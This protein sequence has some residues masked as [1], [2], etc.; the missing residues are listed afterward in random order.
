MYSVKSLALCLTVLTTSLPAPACEQGFPRERLDAEQ[1]Q[2]DFNFKINNDEVF[3][4]MPTVPP[5]TPKWTMAPFYESHL[6]IL[7]VY[8]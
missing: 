3:D 5:P 1:L 8:Y 2:D 6:P 4:T 7:R